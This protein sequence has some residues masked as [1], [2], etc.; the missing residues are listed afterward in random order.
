M[1]QATSLLAS[2]TSHAPTQP[3]TTFTPH[4]ASAPSHEPLLDSLESA[5]GPVGA[6]LIQSLRR[7]IGFLYGGGGAPKRGRDWSLRGTALRL[8]TLLK[9]LF[10]APAVDGRK[11]GTFKTPSTVGRIT[12]WKDGLFGAGVLPE[13]EVREGMGEVIRLARDAAEKGVPEA[14]LLLGDLY[15]VRY[16]AILIRHA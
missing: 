12:R 14:W 7:A 8:R 11:P 13:D 15:L 9:V 3:P 16:I 10:G 5:L 4:Q 6:R 2:I 1:S